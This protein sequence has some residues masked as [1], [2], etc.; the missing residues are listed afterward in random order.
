MNPATIVMVNIDTY[1]DN[2]AGAKFRKREYLPFSGKIDT[3]LAG[4]IPEPKINVAFI[5]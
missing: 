3:G 5:V 2:K 1:L 4:N